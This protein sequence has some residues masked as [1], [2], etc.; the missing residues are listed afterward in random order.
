MCSW[1]FHLIRLIKDRWATVF[2]QS[3]QSELD[4]Q[5]DWKPTGVFVDYTTWYGDRIFR[6]NNDWS[7]QKTIYK[8]AA[9]I[10]TY[11]TEGYWGLSRVKNMDIETFT[12]LRW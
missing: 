2:T 10:S 5:F 12:G 11:P 4:S 3:L 6:Q 9:T 7:D 8:A 1:V